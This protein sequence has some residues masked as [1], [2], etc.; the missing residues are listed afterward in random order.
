M[1]DSEDS[2]EQQNRFMRTMLANNAPT[3]PWICVFIFFMVIAIATALWLPNPSP[4]Q[5]FCFRILI[6]LSASGIAAIIPGFLEISIDWVRVTLKAGGAIGIFVLIYFMNPAGCP[7][8]PPVPDFSGNWTYKCNAIDVDYRH[9]GVCT[10]DAKLTPYGIDFGISGTRTWRQYS[11]A[12]IQNIT[13]NWHSSWGI[14]TDT[15]R[16]RFEYEVEK[17]NAIIHGFA[18]GDIQYTNGKPC[19]LSGN[20]YQVPP[21]DPLFGNM[22][23]IKDH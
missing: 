4:S 15:N 8:P 16:F 19:L 11:N 1:G 18:W 23:F 7:T 10:M 13:F 14:L 22:T 20:F 3:W 21:T 5:Q 12:P 6:A 2:Q 17:D 9:G